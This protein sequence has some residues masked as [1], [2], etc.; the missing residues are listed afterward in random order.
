MIT[1]TTGARVVGTP[2]V[3]TQAE[4]AGRPNFNSWSAKPSRFQS[5]SVPYS[6]VRKRA[7][8]R[9]IHRAVDKSG[10]FSRGRQ[11]S[12]TDLERARLSLGL[13]ADRSKQS[14]LPAK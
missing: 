5:T 14:R 10:T 11:V 13:P 12:L 3:P 2:T 9:A 4:H 6:Q 8:R 7:F 1:A